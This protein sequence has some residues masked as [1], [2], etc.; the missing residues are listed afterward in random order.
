[1]FIANK[2]FWKNVAQM[3]L[4]DSSG[5]NS[6]SHIMPHILNIS[7]DGKQIED[8]IRAFDFN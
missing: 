4:K 6:Q 7:M 8:H 1:M 5:K 3:V 2:V